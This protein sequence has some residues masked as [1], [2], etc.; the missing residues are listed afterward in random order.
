MKKI[1][2]WIAK[3]IFQSLGFLL[4]LGI[5]VW[6]MV[7][8]FGYLRN[9]LR[10]LDIL[11]LWFLPRE[12]WQEFFLSLGS[13]LLMLLFILFVGIILQGILGRWAHTFAD[14]TINTLPGINIFYRAIKQVLT[15]LFREKPKES[16]GVGEVVL[17]KAFQDEAFSMGFVMG[18]TSSLDPTGK[19][20]VK[21]FIPG[22]PNI[23]SGFLTLVEEE[24]LTK[25]HTSL[26]QASA[27]LVSFGIF[28]E[29]RRKQ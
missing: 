26:D 8:L 5:T 3:S 29:M 25:I 24:S 22:V 6:V 11:S 28:N 21:V 20:W 27:F 1:L 7:W 13:F 17:V 18:K 19:T 16:T 9:L 12:P 2:S 15:F 23:S 10:A 4:P 14:K